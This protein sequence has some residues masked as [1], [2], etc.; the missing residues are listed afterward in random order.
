MTKSF[1]ILLDSGHFDFCFFNGLEN[2]SFEVECIGFYGT[3]TT[4]PTRQVQHKCA[5][6]Q[7]LEREEEGKY[8]LDMMNVVCE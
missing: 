2:S 3:A 1:E 6:S 7:G 8:D 4:K 5:C